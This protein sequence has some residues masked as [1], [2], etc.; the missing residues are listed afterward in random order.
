MDTSIIKIRIVFETPVIY[1]YRYSLINLIPKSLFLQFQRAA[2]IYFLIISILSSMSFSPKEP[3]ST[4][5]TFAIVLLFTMIKEAYEV[6]IIFIQCQ[7]NRIKQDRGR[8]ARSIFAGV[9]YSTIHAE[10]GWSDNGSIWKQELWSKSRKTRNFQQICSS[11]R[12]RV[13]MAL[14]MLTHSISMVSLL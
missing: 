4:I 2:N 9:R 6:N 11:W 13:K 8:T 12:A 1:Y 5:A 7:I 14:L 3:A 10:S